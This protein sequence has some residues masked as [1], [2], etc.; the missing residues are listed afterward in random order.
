MQETARILFPDHSLHTVEEL[1]ECDFGDFENK[2]YQE[3]AG[4]PDYQE[5]IESGGMLPFPNGGEQGGVSAAESQGVSE[6]GGRMHQEW[7]I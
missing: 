5:W 3:L 7:D 4:N 2:N 1:A 6:G